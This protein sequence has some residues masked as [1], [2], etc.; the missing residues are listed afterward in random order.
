VK[1]I[2]CDL[3]KETKMGACL[4]IKKKKN[5]EQIK[6]NDGQVMIPVSG[7]GDKK[8]KHDKRGKNDSHG[9]SCE[10]DFHP[11]Q[12]KAKK[13][14]DFSKKK[15]EK[16]FDRYKEFSDAEDRNSEFIGPEGM[17][18]LY[19][20]LEVD[21]EDPVMFILAYRFNATEMAYFSREEFLSGS[22]RLRIDSIEKLKRHLPVLRT[23]LDN[24][25]KMR[26]ICKWAFN[27]SKTEPE[28]K[29]VDKEVACAVFTL[30]FGKYYHITNFVEYLKQINVKVVNFDLWSS[31]YDFAVAVNSDFTNYDE[32]SAWPCLLDDYVK[33]MKDGKVSPQS[34]GVAVNGDEEF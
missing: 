16:L 17:E 24:S 32:N 19:K 30:L 7:G 23:D 22:E 13:D 26:L 14:K 15:L 27:F 8:N 21:S 11:D 10:D 12:K 6:P 25:E 18:K 20:D 2:F 28:H 31:L 33:W 34:N 9:P 3:E 4:A 29:T 1:D 5:A